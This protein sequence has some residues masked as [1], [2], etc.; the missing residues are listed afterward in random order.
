MFI[1]L[2]L[3]SAFAQATTCPQSKDAWTKF[4]DEAAVQI[5]QNTS[6][7]DG[8]ASA[9]RT[10]RAVLKVFDDCYAASTPL[11]AADPAL[12]ASLANLKKFTNERRHEGLPGWL[13]GFNAPDAQYF[14]E[15]SHFTEIPADLK[16]PALLKLLSDPSTI[17]K[18]LK[19]LED[20]NATYDATKKLIFFQY[21]SQHLTTPDESAVFG[22]I[23]IYVPADAEGIEKWVQ[24][25]VPEKGK[26][27]TRNVSVVAIKKDAAGNTDIYF[28]DHFRM[29]DQSEI[30]IKS[31]FEV[32]G[33]GDSC[34]A[35]HK[36]GVLP[37][38]PK[39]GSLSP[40]DQPKLNQVNAIFKDYGPPKFGG[41]V[42]SSSLGP[43]LG[44][45]DPET[46]S[47]RTEDFLTQC[48][49][50]L[51]FE[52]A[53]ESHQ[54][55]AHSMNCASCHN[56]S[57]GF[58]SINYPLNTTVINSYVRGGLMPPRNTLNAVEREGLLSC[59]KSEYRGTDSSKP[60]LLLNWLKGLWTEV[61]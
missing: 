13:M 39:P 16:T 60:A 46:T 20:L 12:G 14:Q 31:R 32:T 21:T 28:K 36:S 57:D 49:K 50:G 51:K 42:D 15:T 3:I 22:R 59:L 47:K 24:F 19:A 8:G 34:I 54:K 25:G 44:A 35:C 27:H 53:A 40:F 58:G 43:A 48:T 26:P 52:N 56:S 45:T 6:D 9:N 7:S 17:D 11:F 55:I 61:F 5:I 1:S 37:V 38:F 10:T 41:Y 33:Q 23:L 2:M 18:A 30:Y 29:Y 4:R